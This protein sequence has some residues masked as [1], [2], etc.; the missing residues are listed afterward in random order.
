MRNPVSNSSAGQLFAN[1]SIL[2]VIKTGLNF[3]TEPFSN[4]F[5][6]LPHVLLCLINDESIIV[7]FCI[8]T[9]IAA[10]NPTPADIEKYVPVKKSENI[11]PVKATIIED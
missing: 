3:C 10:I 1:V 8:D 6:F 5:I 2:A 11:H 9:P 4:E 7:P